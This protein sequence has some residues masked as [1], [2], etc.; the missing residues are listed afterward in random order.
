MKDTPH[1]MKMNGNSY[2]D[3]KQT[4]KLPPPMWKNTHQL[5][6]TSSKNQLSYVNNLKN[7]N[8]NS[9]KYDICYTGT[10]TYIT[11]TTP[12]RTLSTATY[13][14]GTLLPPTL[15]LHAEDTPSSH[16]DSTP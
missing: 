12:E 9:F 15:H 14:S 7:I 6:N 16:K 8:H 1:L 5:I 10:D 2:F 3:T 11:P 4:Q 13:Y